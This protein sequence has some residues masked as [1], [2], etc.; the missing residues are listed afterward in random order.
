MNKKLIL[1]SAHDCGLCEQ[2]EQLL[3]ECDQ[4]A[5]WYAGIKKIDVKTERQ[6]FHLYGARI[7]VIKRTDKEC[8]LAWP[9][10]KQQ[11]IEFLS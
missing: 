1:F 6:Y 4:I 7:P 11:L 5:S 8:D 3:R 9:F 10:D 2:A